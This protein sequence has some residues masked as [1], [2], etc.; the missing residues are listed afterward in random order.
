MDS[1]KAVVLEGARVTVTSVTS[2]FKL[3]ARTAARSFSSSSKSTSTPF[4]PGMIETV[5]FRLIE[6]RASLGSTIISAH[7][8][9]TRRSNLSLSNSI[10]GSKEIPVLLNILLSRQR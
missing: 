3:P 4:S 1:R 9:F 2:G 6:N 10:A 5:S 7:S 8:S